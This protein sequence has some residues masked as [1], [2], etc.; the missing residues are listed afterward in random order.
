MQ[1]GKHEYLVASNRTSNHI[2][3]VKLKSGRD[4]VKEGP[5]FQEWDF[6]LGM[7]EMI[8]EAYSESITKGC[9]KFGGWMC[10]T[11]V[12]MFYTNSFEA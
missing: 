8:Q 10:L 2:H 1:K 7:I 4:Y 9:T 3:K 11:N 5:T 6:R 12:M